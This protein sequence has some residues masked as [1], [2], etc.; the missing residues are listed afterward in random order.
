MNS[1]LDIGIAA[2]VPAA[3]SAAW[4]VFSCSAKVLNDHQFFVGDDV[5]RDEQPGAADGN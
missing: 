4:A 1:T 3:I 2:R 5:R